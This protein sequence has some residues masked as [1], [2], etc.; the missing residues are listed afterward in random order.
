MSLA[1]SPVTKFARGLVILILTTTG[2]NAGTFTFNT[3]TTGQPKFNRPY[4]NGTTAP[5]TF[6]SAIGTN[7]SYLSTSFIVG[8]SGSYSVT[9]ISTVPANWDNFIILYAGSFNPAAPLTN[10]VIL[11]DDLGGV[12]GKA[13]FT[14]SLTSG[15]HYFLVTTGFANSDAGT[16]I[17][18]VTGPGTITAAPEPGTLLIMT[19]GLSLILWKTKHRSGCI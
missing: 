3:V 14:V 5:P 4:D 1:I 10:A 16:A 17:N 7:V 6:L 18:T 13:G 2:L 11:N 12:I 15:V 9:S 19:A 8:T